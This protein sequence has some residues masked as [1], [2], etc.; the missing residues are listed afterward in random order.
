MNQMDLKAL[1]KINL[2]LDV[3]GK[4]GK[5]LSHGADGYADY[6]SLR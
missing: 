3:L 6:L 2:G 1:A 4:Q 5:R